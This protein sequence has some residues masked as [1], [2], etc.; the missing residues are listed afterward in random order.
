M[1]LL[2]LLPGVRALAA[3]RCI[4]VRDTAAAQDVRLEAWGDNAIRVRAVPA[5][6]AFR[7]DL[8]SALLPPAGYAG[9]GA[10]GGGGDGSGC[11]T[12]HLGAAG[13]SLSNG[14]LRATVGADGRLAYTRLSDGAPLLREQSVRAFGTPADSALSNGTYAERFSSLDMAFEPAAAERIYGLGQHAALNGRGPTSGAGQINMKGVKGLLMQ[15]NNG[16]ILIPVA[17]SSL[18]YAFLFNLPALGSVEYNGVL[19]ARRR[20]AAGGLLGGHHGRRLPGGHHGRR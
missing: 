19:L 15:P 4:A 2:L 9:V 6:G 18:G 1:A 20:G 17:H 14:N 11:T 5:G 16:E 3:E 10:G 13:Q 8:V 7:D 12:V